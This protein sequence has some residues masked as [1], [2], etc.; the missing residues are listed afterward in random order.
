MRRASRALQHRLARALWEAVADSGVD[1]GSVENA[2][3]DAGRALRASSRFRQILGHPGVELKAKMDLLESI[4]PLRGPAR[5]LMEALIARRALGALGGVLRTYR[6]L[7][8]REA[9]EVRA[10]VSVATALSAAEREAIR[11]TLERSLGRKVAVSVR[12]ERELIGGMMIQV[13]ERIV[14]GTVKGAFDRLE[15][16]LVTAGKERI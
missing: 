15:R 11:E 8:A 9:T 12:R 5:D 4:V 3:D 14:D 10:T 7:A 16:S 2:L 6:S 13:G 1:A